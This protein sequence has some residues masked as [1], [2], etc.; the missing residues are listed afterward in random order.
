MTTEDSFVQPAIP[1]F[2]GHYDHWSM[3][4]EN[5]LRSREYSQVVESRISALADDADYSDEQKKVAD[6][7][8]KDL[9]ATFFRPSIAQFWR[10]FWIKK[11]RKEL[12]IQ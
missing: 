4:R 9:R 10:L 5:F 2:V 8:S 3:L 12:G 11:L 7:K 6:Q 1:K